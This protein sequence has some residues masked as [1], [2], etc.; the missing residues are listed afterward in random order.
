M[1]ARTILLVDDEPDILEAL[2]E[3]LKLE[4]EGSEI[5]LAK[6]GPT[7]L[8]MIAAGKPDLIVSDF[9][10]PGMNGVEFLSQVKDRFGTIP[11]IMLT[12]FPD[13]QLAVDAARRGV[14]RRFYTKP[15]DLD[16]VLSG[17]REILEPGEMTS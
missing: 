12:A 13:R 4:I 6:D 5:Q 3:L 15:P 14:I 10:M 16:L 11:A 9:R 1:P 8:E 2:G 17:I 7:G